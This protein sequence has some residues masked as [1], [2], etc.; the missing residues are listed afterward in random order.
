MTHYTSETLLSQVQRLRADSE[1]SKYEVNCISQLTKIYGNF[2]TIIHIW[3]QILDKQTSENDKDKDENIRRALANAYYAKSKRLWSNLNKKELRRICELMENNLR[4]DAT[5]AADIRMW[6]QAFRR[7]PEFTYI[8][9]LS[10]LETWAKMGNALEA[11]YYLYILHFLLWQQGI[12]TNESLIGTNL[13]ECRKFALGKR[14]HCYE[15]LAKSPAWCPLIFYKE[16]G[17]FNKQIGFYPETDK[18]RPFAGFIESIKG[19][20][21]GTIRISTHLSAFFV[22]GTSFWSPEHLNKPVNFFLGFSYDGFRAWSV[23]PAHVSN[24]EILKTESKSVIPTV[25]EDEN[26]IANSVK[27]NMNI[28]TYDK[29][30]KLI[31]RTI[32][33]SE[34]HGRDLKLTELSRELASKFPGTKTVHERLGFK[35]VKD[36]INSFQI[37]RVDGKLDSPIIRLR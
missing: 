27:D 37:F 16:L 28:D 31:Y 8:D 33:K 3:E 21:A 4:N 15:W 6:F 32:K 10:R 13:D 25:R 19:P 26:L 34:S 12:E 7:L 22:P 5:N 20:Q 11:Y 23:N 36:L 30:R 1:P 2:D 18:L 35:N 17:E 29:I 24:L 14:S 9:A